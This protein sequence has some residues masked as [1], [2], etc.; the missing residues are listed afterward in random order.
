MSTS[1]TF[2]HAGALAIADAMVSVTS[3]AAQSNPYLARLSVIY[4]TVDYMRFVP[5]SHRFRSSERTA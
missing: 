4:I 2:H 1:G 3:L 5:R